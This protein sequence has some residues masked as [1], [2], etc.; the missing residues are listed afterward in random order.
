MPLN[1]LELSKQLIQFRSINPPGEEKE[2]SEFIA[3]LLTEHGFNVTSYEFAKDRP[4]LVA[5]IPG[6]AGGKPLW[7]VS[8]GVV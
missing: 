8:P 4:T 6:T 2:C 1:G 3:R 7:V 5:R